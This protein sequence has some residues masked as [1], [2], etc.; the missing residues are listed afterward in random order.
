[1]KYLRTGLVFAL[2]LIAGMLAIAPGTLTAAGLP[3]LTGRIV[4]SC[5]SGKICLYDLARRTNVKFNVSGVNPKFSKDGTKIVFQASK[6]IGV[7]NSDGTGAKT[8]STFG[9]V[10][11][12]SPDG[13]KIAFDSSGI[14][15][16]NADGSGLVEVANS[17]YF[18]TWSPSTIQPAQIAFSSNV[19]SSSLALWSMNSDGTNP[20]QI[21]AGPGGD[22][23]DVVWSSSGQIVFA[24]GLSKQSG[25]DEI[26]AFNP[27][28]LALTRLT[29]SAGYDY[30]PAASPDGTL[31]AFA[32]GRS[33]AGIYIMNADGSTPTLIISGGR[34]PSW[35]P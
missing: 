13:T 11:S 35:G 26:F 18:A 17:G 10:P 7:M 12:W 2:A 31:I 14:W 27:S 21:L 30:E 16:M 32:S 24:G 6:G 20:R 19:S 29:N 23:I 1:M 25:G 22:D 28:N 5:S 3:A 33:P 8:V 4:Y 15:V 34:Q 9:G